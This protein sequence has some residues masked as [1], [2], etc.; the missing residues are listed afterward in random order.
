MLPRAPLWPRLQAPPSPPGVADVFRPRVPQV[1]Q[2]GVARG[3]RDDA[4]RKRL[5]ARATTGSGEAGAGIWRPQGARN[6]RC[7]LARVQNCPCSA[8]LPMSRVTHYWKLVRASVYG[9]GA[10]SSILHSW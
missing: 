10:G 9:R 8:S 4:V 5:V 6:A 2:R 3:E 1:E 7:Q